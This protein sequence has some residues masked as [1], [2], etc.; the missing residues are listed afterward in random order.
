[1]SMIKRHRLAVLLDI[2]IIKESELKLL[3]VSVIIPN[4]FLPQIWI[5]ATTPPQP[6]CGR[7]RRRRPIN[8]IVIDIINTI[9]VIIPIR[10]SKPFLG[11]GFRY[12]NWRTNP[13][14]PNVVR[15]IRSRRSQ[16]DIVFGSSSS[17]TT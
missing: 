12:T 1:M 17:N 11:N 2:E 4:R 15:N 16:N 8:L 13:R 14:I 9:F 7:T 5:R 10:K 3:I 6:K